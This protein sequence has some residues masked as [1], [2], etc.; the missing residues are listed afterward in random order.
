MNAI[1]L[2]QKS[3]NLSFIFFSSINE[4]NCSKFGISTDQ[5]DTSEINF[6]S[7]TISQRHPQQV[8][9]QSAD[10]PGVRHRQLLRV[11]AFTGSLSAGDEVNQF[12][13][14]LPVEENVCMADKKIPVLFIGNRL[15][16]IS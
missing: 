3:P 9:E 10:H 7:K 6:Q 8:A 13:R 4:T 2:L 11:T 1:D 15:L 5:R 12:L 16:G 14:H